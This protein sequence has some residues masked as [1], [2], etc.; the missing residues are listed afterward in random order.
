MAHYVAECLFI[1][2]S[3]AG[4]LP[5][6]LEGAGGGGGGGGARDCELRPSKKTWRLEAIC[7]SVLFIL[8]GYSTVQYD[9]IIYNF[10]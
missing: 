3:S 5:R 7:L 4:G 2:Y 8:L 1:F 6:V 10:I 9:T